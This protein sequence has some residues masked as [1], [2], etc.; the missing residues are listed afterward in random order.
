MG[1]EWE[2][3]T[4]FIGQRMAHNFWLYT[5]IDDIMLHKSVKAIIELGTGTGGI[6]MVLGLWG[7]RLDIP[8]ISI[9]TDCVNPAPIF[10]I[11]KRLGVLFLNMDVF[12]DNTM[13]IVENVINQGP[14]FLLCDNG[15][16]PREVSLYAPKLLPGSVLGVH[17]YGKEF[18]ALDSGVDRLYDPYKEDRWSERGAN[19]AIYMRNLLSRD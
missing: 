5:L 15:D 14:V 2:W 8:V 16:K 13:L 18:H 4:T 3:F 6:T 19:L 17:D 11:F 7:A 10:P 12:A 9:D 1:E